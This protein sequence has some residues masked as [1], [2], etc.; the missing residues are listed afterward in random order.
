MP[1]PQKKIER[2][3]WVIYALIAGIVAVVMALGSVI[4]YFSR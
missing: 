1:P 2:S 4:W 3:Q